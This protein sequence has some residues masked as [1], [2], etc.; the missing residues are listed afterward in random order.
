MRLVLLLLLLLLTQCTSHG[1]PGADVVFE[2]FV[3]DEDI[4][5]SLQTIDGA[6]FT[7]LLRF[8][9]QP[10][11]TPV[12]SRDIGIVDVFSR[13]LYPLFDTR[14]ARQ[15]HPSAHTFDARFVFD[16]GYNYTML[17]HDRLIFGQGA[18]WGVDDERD[19]MPCLPDTKALCVVVIDGTRFTFFPSSGE[20]FFDE[21]V[22]ETKSLA[23]VLLKPP[24]SWPTIPTRDIVVPLRQ[25]LRERTV[26]YD[27]VRHWIA[28]GERAPSLETR[29]A[30]AVCVFLLTGL[31]F[32][33]LKVADV[34]GGVCHMFAYVVVI[35]SLLVAFASQTA[36]LRAW[37]FMVATLVVV[38]A[39]IAMGAVRACKEWTRDA[40]PALEMHPLL[41]LMWVALTLGLYAIRS[42]SMV[43]VPM[44]LI[45][46]FTAKL[47]ADVISLGIMQGVDVPPLW[48]TGGHLAFN[49]VYAGFMWHYIVS[50]FL[51]TSVEGPWELQV[52]VL[53][54]VVTLAALVMAMARAGV[55]ICD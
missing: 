49:L 38:V 33:R 26:V 9:A 17:T 18:P 24:H 11:L 15:L 21:L 51:D 5:I 20:S 6:A 31:F 32:T 46:A 22:T 28:L 45:M 53:V 44:L 13:I 39:N 29:L 19:W 30:C 42:H 10:S 47:A 34:F 41:V 12:D 54:L 35:V 3:S 48:L 4:R 1:I 16:M 25:L 52:T 2:S 14:V 36:A 50:E 7:P 23:G 8:A 27:A 43:I 55:F 37:E 40:D